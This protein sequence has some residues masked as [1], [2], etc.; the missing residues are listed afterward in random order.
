MKSE[1]RKLMS[2]TSQARR[3]NAKAEMK[4]RFI[5]LPDALEPL[6]ERF[7]G[8]FVQITETMSIFSWFTA[9]GTQLFTTNNAGELRVIE[10]D[11]PDDDRGIFV[12][13]NEAGDHERGLIL[14]R[15]GDEDA[16]G[17][18]VADIEALD[19]SLRGMGRIPV[20]VIASCGDPERRDR[21]D[22]QWACD[23]AK[24][25]GLA[26]IAVNEFEASSGHVQDAAG[27]FEWQEN[28]ELVRIKD[29]AE[30]IFTLLGGE[31]VTAD[32]ADLWPERPVGWERAAGK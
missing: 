11:P 23:L 12:R 27:V 9:P 22:L 18:C 13:A 2:T 4:L 17:G 30:Q 1:E 15:V 14:A 21:T 7:G 16:L 10:L 29:D 8:P 3:R 25:N 28:S 31:L 20:A 6:V 26:W 19:R 5:Q 32:I 24:S